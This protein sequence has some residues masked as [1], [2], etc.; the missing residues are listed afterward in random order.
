[1]KRLMFVLMAVVAMAGVAMAVIP[2]TISQ[3]IDATGYVAVRLPANEGCDAFVLWPVD[4]SDYYVASNA[5][6]SDGILHPEGMPV[7]DPTKHSGHPDGA[8]LCYVKGTTS[9]TIVG[10]FA[11]K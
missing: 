2:G 5:D 10:R 9:T 4:G 3:D 7:T 1:M 11:Q 6:G 8:I